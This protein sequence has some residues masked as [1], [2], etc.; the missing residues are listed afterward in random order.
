MK[1]GNDLSVV[2]SSKVSKNFG[3]GAPSYTEDTQRADHSD[4]KVDGQNISDIQAN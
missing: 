3:E 2:A 1:G 4:I